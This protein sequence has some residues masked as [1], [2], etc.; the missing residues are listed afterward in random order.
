MDDTTKQQLVLSPQAI[1]I[2]NTFL[3]SLKD[4]TSSPSRSNYQLMSATNSMVHAHDDDEL[5]DS[6]F[7]IS[8]T[9]NS[10]VAVR[11]QNDPNKSKLLAFEPDKWE[12]LRNMQAEVNRYL[13]NSK[14]TEETNEAAGNAIDTQSSL[15]FMSHLNS[16]SEA[17]QEANTDDRPGSA[18][19]QLKKLVESQGG[20]SV[21][22]QS[23]P[24]TQMEN[25]A[26]KA[27]AFDSSQ[28]DAF[29]SLTED[30]VRPSA[31]LR[32]SKL[33]DID[34]IQ[35]LMDLNADDKTLLKS[36]THS[37][38]LKVY[39]KCMQVGEQYY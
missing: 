8:H 24:A 36:S 34:P 28:L 2:K 1:D 35:N 16:K 30:K 7:E 6:A 9:Q 23:R 13:L 33:D 37:N 22:A 27:E 38:N 11:F 3:N 4:S 5:P 15:K 10:I 21:D 39:E 32:K 26:D 29:V 31:A 19:D 18:F 14:I 25:T 17:A 20:S 12:K